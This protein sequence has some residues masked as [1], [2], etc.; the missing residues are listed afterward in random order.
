MLVF[1]AIAMVTMMGF[2]ALTIDVGSG[3]RNRRIAQTAADA[4]AI[5]GAAELWKGNFGLASGAALTEAV[6]NGFASSEV[7]VNYPPASGPH[8][9]DPAYIE[10]LIDKTI[11]TIF[12]TI[13]NVSSMN[14]HTRA[15]AGYGMHSLNCIFTLDPDGAQ[16]LEVTNGAE[17][18]TNCG[19]TINSTD[20]NAL[21]TNSSG[22]IDTGGGGIAIAGNWTGNKAPV[23][24]PSTG[25]APVINPLST[26]VMPSMGACTHTGML[27]I[28]KDTA[29][30][31]GVYCGGLDV[32]SKTVNLAPGTYYFAGGGVRIANGG[33]LL[34]TGVT[35][36]NTVDPIGTYL[37]GPIDFGN[38]CKTTLSAPT[39]G[40]WKGIVMY[41]DPAA[42]ADVVN[43]FACSSDNP[44][45]L[46]GTIYF[47]TQTISFNG[48]NTTT[49]ILGSVIAKNVEI[50]AKVNVLNQT[51]ASAA[52]QRFA[53]VE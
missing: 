6:R 13:F 21:D 49:T 41:Q 34:G 43:T 47:P 29:L 35:L 28:T 5:G 8:S 9:G 18:T 42:P 7:T 12:G 48:S 38:G 39:T 14:I 53:L 30:S 37:F 33:T 26:L 51:S 2:L 19:I 44:P 20:P 36:V 25:S 3:G 45:E 24:V 22:T 46:T 15:V 40:Y 4:G 50:S 17:L 23:P 27:L 52:V 32:A 1:V 31:P 10:V 11:P 16:A